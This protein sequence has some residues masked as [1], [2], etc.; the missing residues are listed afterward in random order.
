MNI[1]LQCFFFD[2]RE[3]GSLGDIGCSGFILMQL[4]YVFSVFSFSVFGWW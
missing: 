4:G 3:D 1:T 2:S